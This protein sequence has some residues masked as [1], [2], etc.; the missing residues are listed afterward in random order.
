MPAGATGPYRR[1][2]AGPSGYA[3]AMREA[4]RRYRWAVIPAA[5][6]PL[7]IAGYLAVIHPSTHPTAAQAHFADPSTGAGS[8]SPAASASTSPGPSA[9]P[10]SAPLPAGPGLRGCPNLPAGNV[11]H[12][13]VS[14]LPALPGSAAYVASIGTGARVKADFGAG[15][16]DGGPIGIPIT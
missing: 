5:A 6:V 10:S 16:W 15:L 13:D 2:G 4:W 7:L 14:R 3:T 8:A 1:S 11:W 12:A 9:T